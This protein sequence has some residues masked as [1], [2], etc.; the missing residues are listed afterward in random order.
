MKTYQ[1]IIAFALL[2]MCSCTARQGETTAEGDSIEMRYA[3]LLSLQQGEGY[4]SAEIKNPWDSTK[5]LHR[6]ILVPKDSE[7]P[8]NL[9]KGD[10]IRTPLEHAVFYTSVHVSLINQLGA[11]GCIAGV[12]DSEYMYLDRLQK[13]VKAGKIADCGKGTA[14]NI[15]KVIDL[16]PDAVLLSPF[17]NSGSYGKLGTIGIPIVECAD[18]METSALGRAEWM[19]FYGLLTGRQAEADSLFAGIEQRYNDLKARVG[20]ASA[21]DR[22]NPTVLLDKKFG[23]TWYMA[24]ANSTTGRL[25]AD[26]GADY[27]FNSEKSAG[28]V[29]YDP[30]VVFDRGQQ[31]ELWLIKYNQ[32]ADMTYAQLAN[33]WVNYS[34][35]AAF[36]HKNVYACN[37]S[38]VPF[39]EETPFHPDLLLRDYIIIF[40]PEAIEDHTLRYFR[41][42]EK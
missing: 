1:Y 41:K 16:S 29:P 34:K 42:L 17:E 10:V 5:T 13:D 18:Y 7:M 23:S 11:Y 6:Y 30:E 20:N 39:Y 38:K 25:L 2:L 14:P 28:S 36:E 33:E 26:A 24:G 19:R 3:T 21:K 9:P 35:I 8:A 37:L 4:I 32:D 40:H 22:K 12:C 31:A 27:I 15:E